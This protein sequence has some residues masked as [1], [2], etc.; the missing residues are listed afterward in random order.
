MT[1]GFLGINSKSVSYSI[2]FSRIGHTCFLF[3]T[4]E[5]L[6]FNLNNRI[7]ITDE[8]E[9]LMNLVDR[10]NIIATTDVIEVITNSEII[11]SF[12][13]CQSNSDGTFDI[14]P[15]M[16]IVQQFYLASHLD[17]LLYD[18]NFIISS[19]L[20]PGDSKMIYEK[21]SQFGINFGYF[22][23]FIKDGKVFKTIQN[24]MIYV[25]GTNSSELGKVFSNLIRQIRNYNS[26]VILVSPESAELL[27]FAISSIIANKIII[28]NLIGDLMINMGL[29]NE[30]KIVLE[31]INKSEK[32][33]K[34]N[35]KYNF[36]FENSI[37]GKEINAFSN[38]SQTKKIEVNIFDKILEA[39]DEHLKY[40]K[41]F[42]MSLNQNKSNPFVIEYDLGKNSSISFSNSQIFK[43]CLDFLNEGYI[44]N[45]IYNHPIDNYLQK[46]SESFEFRLKFFKKE[47]NPDGFKI[48]L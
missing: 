42:Y 8:S 32:N 43:L 20:N 30:I 26:E 27:K 5:D 6:V 14:S 35:L 9:I 36:G 16:D 15:I 22:P 24:E 7:F 11:I 2:L 45:V 38:F 40:L 13:D 12:V 44:V 1:I 39:N 18:K 29:K 10:I 34:E 37:L 47:T 17:I 46:L 41:Y 4:N 3:D 33:S 25:L 28:S 48:N 31:T 21:I 19:V 23:N